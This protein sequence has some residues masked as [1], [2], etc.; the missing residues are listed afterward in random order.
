MKRSIAYTVFTDASTAHTGTVYKTERSCGLTAVFKCVLSDTTGTVDLN[1]YVSQDNSTWVLY[2]TTTLTATGNYAF[3][4]PCRNHKYV[5]IATANVT[6]M[7]TSCT[8]NIAAKGT[9]VHGKPITYTALAARTTAGSTTYDVSNAVDMQVFWTNTKTGTGTS[10]VKNV[11]SVSN[12]GVVFVTLETATVTSTLARTT[13]I[14][15]SAKPY[16]Y[17]KVANTEVTTF[18]VT[19]TAKITSYVQA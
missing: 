8:V 9:E 16:K 4:V 10:T 12:D 19:A 2:A 17:V 11:V 18:T 15:L 3:D 1:V 13:N 7:T 14:D 6:T 5:K